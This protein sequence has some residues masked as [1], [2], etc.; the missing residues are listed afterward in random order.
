MQLTMMGKGL[1]TPERTQRNIDSFKERLKDLC[2]KVEVIE[3]VAHSPKKEPHKL[4][5]DNGKD[6]TIPK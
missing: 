3:E 1:E 2:S 6:E 4:D 5:G